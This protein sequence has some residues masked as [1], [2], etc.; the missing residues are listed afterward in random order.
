MKGAINQGASM[1]R[2]K[3]SIWVVDDNQKF[4]DTIGSLVASA[5]DLECN[6]TFSSCEQMFAVLGSLP[7][8]AHPDVVLM[9]YKL[10]AVGGPVRMNG[11]E[12]ARRLKAMDPDIAIVMLTQSDEPDTIYNAIGAGARGYLVKPPQIDEVVD[13]I[14]LAH[15]GGMWMPPDVASKVN[16]FFT[17]HPEPESDPELKPLTARERDVLL[18][19]ARGYRQ[20][21]IA[22]NLTMSR[23]TVDSHIRS[24]YDKLHAHSAA[25]AVAKGLVTGE[26]RLGIADWQ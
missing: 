5:F 19:M 14:R 7:A 10:T 8:E 16:H 15:R 20:K 22:V 24:I 26:I 2:T 1:A 3:L 25:E 12:G 23:H 9:D 11:I 13:A 4:R 21:E 18:G 17:T 6:H